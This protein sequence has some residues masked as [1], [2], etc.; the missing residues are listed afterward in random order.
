MVLVVLLN[1]IIKKAKFFLMNIIASF[2]YYYFT[3]E[4][5]PPGFAD[6]LS[7]ESECQRVFSDLQDS[8]RYAGRSQQQC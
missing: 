5:F 6:G 2:I 3:C 8:S 7:L 1:Q 4:F